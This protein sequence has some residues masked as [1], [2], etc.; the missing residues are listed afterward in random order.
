MADPTK[1]QATARA[2]VMKCEQEIQS[3]KA[4]LRKLGA[5][6]ANGQPNSMEIVLLKVCM[7]FMCVCMCADVCVW[8]HCTVVVQLQSI[9]ASIKRSSQLIPLDYIIL[10]L[11]LC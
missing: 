1:E 5:S 4:A 10:L 11:L 6:E 3:I 8:I 2:E 9:L 7:V